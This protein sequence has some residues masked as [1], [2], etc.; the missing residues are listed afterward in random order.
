MQSNEWE[1]AMRNIGEE[2]KRFDESSNKKEISSCLMI[3]R[4]IPFCDLKIGYIL[5]STVPTEETFSTIFRF[6][7]KQ[8]FIFIKFDPIEF[9]DMNSLTVSTLQWAHK[10]IFIPS[11]HFLFDWTITIDLNES[12]EVLFSR[13]RPSTRHNIRRAQ[14]N[15]IVIKEM[16]NPAGFEIFYSLYKKTCK[17]KVYLG[18]N[19]TYFK[20]LFSSL[21]QFTHIFIAYYKNRPL[22]AYEMIVFNDTTYYL[23]GGTSEYLNSTGAS[24]LLMWE[25]ILFGKRMGM[26]SFDMWGCLGPDTYKENHSWY[27]FTRFKLGFGGTLKQYAAS[28]DLVINEPI[29]KKYNFTNV[30]VKK[31]KNSGLLISDRNYKFV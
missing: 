8:N 3:I 21:R 14:K 5:R 19:R 2:V 4:Q 17:R 9:A 22:A 15:N 1:D 28:F 7:K 10:N 6:A 24:H 13:L 29:Y 20:V 12:Q 30:F 18:N 31:L 27:G 26:K 25:A 11:S 16:T 23:Y